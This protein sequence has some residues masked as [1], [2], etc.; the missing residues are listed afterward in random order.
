MLRSWYWLFPLTSVQC[1]AIQHGDGTPVM[2]LGTFITCKAVRRTTIV[3]DVIMAADKKSC[4]PLDGRR[5]L[6]AWGFAGLWRC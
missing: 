4:I 1:E 3:E 2:I 6:G 5:I